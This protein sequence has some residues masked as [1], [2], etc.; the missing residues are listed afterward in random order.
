MPSEDVIRLQAIIKKLMRDRGLRYSDLAAHLG[1]SLATVKRYLTRPDISVEQLSS[2]SK[3]LGLGLRELVNITYD[4]K[5][6]AS[7]VSEEQEEFLALNSNYCAYLGALMEGFAPHEIAK[8]HGLNA[9][10]TRKYLRGLE[11][12][13]LIEVGAG[14]RVRLLV[15]RFLNVSALPKLRQVFYSHLLDVAHEHFKKKVSAP[16]DALLKLVLLRL[17]HTTYERM[18]AELRALYDKYL[19]AHTYET[20]L[21]RPDALVDVTLILLADTWVHGS[22]KAVIRDI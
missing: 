3:W 17:S 10:S 12:A 11:Q 13:H 14:G 15:D 2:V 21:E 19:V 16:D 8:R 5:P 4:E 20:R 18:A 7:V 1:V 6:S 22:F 9:H